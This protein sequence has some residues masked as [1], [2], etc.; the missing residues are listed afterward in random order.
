MLF[1]GGIRYPTSRK[2]VLSSPKL[3]SLIHNTD[4]D[5]TNDTIHIA[6]DQFWHEINDNEYFIDRDPTHFRYILNYIRNNKHCVLP[7]DPSI[8]KELSI[9]ANF[10]ELH[11][12]VTLLNYK[13]EDSKDIDKIMN[14]HGTINMGSNIITR[15]ESNLLIEWIDDNDG[16]D[17]NEVYSIDLLYRGSDYDFSAEKFHD[18]CDHKG[19]TLTII[20]AENGFVFG[21]YTHFSWNTKENVKYHNYG[22]SQGFI[23]LLRA[24]GRDQGEIQKWSL[25]IDHY[26]DIQTEIK[27]DINYGPSFIDS[28]TIMDKCNKTDDNEAYLGSMFEDSDEIENK[29]TILS[30]NKNFKVQEYEVF[31]VAKVDDY[32]ILNHY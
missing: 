10:Y 14:Q 8:R 32:K 28:I 26:P 18:L 12:L 25:D 6:K 17:S 27:N 24:Y 3:S 1:L 29:D 22:R 21:G 4:Y 19:K 15:D 31:Q 9:E 2:T 7:T 13:M 5:K 23:Y 30:G 11:D 20:Q 16:D